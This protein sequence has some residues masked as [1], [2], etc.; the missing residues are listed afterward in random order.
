MK[1]SVRYGEKEHWVELLADGSLWR[2]IVD[3]E[4]AGLDAAELAPGAYSILTDGRSREVAV[5]RDGDNFVVRLGGAAYEMTVLD[6][7]RARTRRPERALG[8][9][10]PATL[11]APMPGLVVEIKA[12]VGD[13]LEAGQPLVVM[14]AMK[15]QNELGSP[16]TGKVEKIHVK[17]GQSVESGQVLVTLGPAAEGA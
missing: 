14:E 8:A 17:I 16:G 4:E 7:V 1:F 5:S 15:M 13:R 9:G 3:G 10:G 11:R 6:E 2:A 12:A